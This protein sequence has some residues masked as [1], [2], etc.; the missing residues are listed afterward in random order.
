MFEPYRFETDTCQELLEELRHME[1]KIEIP[2]FAVPDEV[3]SFIE[4]PSPLL[5]AEGPDLFCPCPRE[6]AS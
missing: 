6:W 4:Q 5:I 2:P 1:T 3:Y